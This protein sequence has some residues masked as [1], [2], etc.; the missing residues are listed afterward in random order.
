MITKYI[1]MIKGIDLVGMEEYSYT[2]K[3][4]YKNLVKLKSKYKVKFYLHAGEVINSDKSLT[5]LIY[6]I[7]LNSIRIGHGIVAFN[8]DELL[9]KIKNKNIFLEI[10]PTS[11][12]LLFNYD[13]NINNIINNINNIVI[14]SDDDNKFMTNL[15]NEYYFLYKN[16]LKLK[17]IYTLLLNSSKFI[18][19]FNKIKFD[20]E[21]NIFKKNLY[22]NIRAPK[23]K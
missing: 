11:N 19:N 22:I 17:Y 15:S 23:L 13:I 10:C 2:L 14:C 7:K 4:H 8:N 21:F 18:N 16:G 9:Q 12:K 5:N 1:T 3:Y 20:K 6:A